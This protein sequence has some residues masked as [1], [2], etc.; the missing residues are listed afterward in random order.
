MVFLGRPPASIYKRKD[1]KEKLFPRLAEAQKVSAL[2]MQKI[3]IQ[4]RHPQG[5]TAILA[6]VG[7]LIYALWVF[8]K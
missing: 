8:T 2:Q 1:L 7:V 3:L 5:V 4:Q 6:L